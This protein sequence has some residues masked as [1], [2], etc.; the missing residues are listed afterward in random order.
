MQEMSLQVVKLHPLAQISLTLVKLVTN[1]YK[2]GDTRAIGVQEDA[3]G[4]DSLPFGAAHVV[5]DILIVGRIGGVRAI[6]QDDQRPTN[7]NDQELERRR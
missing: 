4:V 1:D 7:E 5:N 3:N 6:G 2:V